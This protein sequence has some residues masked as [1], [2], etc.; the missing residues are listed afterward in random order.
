MSEL[1]HIVA[2]YLKPEVIEEALQ[3]STRLG[4]E[5]A[6]GF[7][8]N[9][10]N[11]AYDQSVEPFDKERLSYNRSGSPLALV[12]HRHSDQGKT[13]FLSFKIKTIDPLTIYLGRNC[14]AVLWNYTDE[15]Q[16]LRKPTEP[17]I[18]RLASLLSASLLE[19]RVPY[20][21]RYFERESQ[22][23]RKLK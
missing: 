6:K 23:E 7:L 21:V 14:E 18:T 4:G 19:L 2:F 9:V 22:V 15:L 12:A 16:D 1:Q 8:A 5:A 13:D 3:A 20:S 11:D 10:V 17:A